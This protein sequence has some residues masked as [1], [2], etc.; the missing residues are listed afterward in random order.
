M[1]GDVEWQ[2]G[3]CDYS[4]DF[5]ARKGR[6][7]F[8]NTFRRFA[9]RYIRVFSKEIQINYIG[10]RPVQR[11][12]IEIKRTFKDNLLQRI[13]DASVATLKG[14]MHEHYEDG[15]FREQAMYIYDTRNQ[16]LFGYSAFK[17]FSFAREN[18][19]FIAKGQKEDGIMP[20]T[21]PTSINLPI[22]LFSLMYVLMVHEYIKYSGDLSVY[23]EIKDVL[24]KIMEAFTSRVEENGLIAQFPFP[25][26]NYYDWN[27]DVP[28]LGNYAQILRKETDPYE[29]KYDVI[30][31]C[32]YI[33]ACRWYGEISGENIDTK[34]T[35]EAVKKHFF[36]EEKGLF[37]LEE[38]TQLYTRL[39]N[40]LA[41]LAGLA[42]EKVAEKMVLEEDIIDVSLS[43][44]PFCYDALL[45]FGDKYKEYILNEIKRKFGKMLD[46]GFNVCWE[47]D[48]GPE[49]EGNTMLHAWSSFPAHYLP[50]Y[51]SD[52]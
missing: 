31:N 30:L 46:A 47:T 37:T 49:E 17:G 38:G 45:Q 48:G 52:K 51:F 15:P 20:I 21:S 39:G 42:D 9:C 40:S 1:T 23:N 2:I 5:K 25:Y 33:L 44:N 6:N 4:M 35:E 24:K 28:N 26:W 41:M 7:V 18:L 27:V 13:Y 14:C 34:K 12:I 3:K 29:K 36:D 43:M 8:L 19:L 50:I 32:V 22:P 16:M 10:I 11:Q